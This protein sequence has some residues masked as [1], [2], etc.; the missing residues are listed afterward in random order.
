MFFRFYCHSSIVCANSSSV[1]PAAQVRLRSR[2]DHR[3]RRSAHHHRRPRP[4]ILR[5]EQQ[6]PQETGTT[7]QAGVKGRV[8]GRL[9]MELLYIA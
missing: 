8:G 1:D 9:G 4:E 5:P 3:P 7:R 2:R 6:G